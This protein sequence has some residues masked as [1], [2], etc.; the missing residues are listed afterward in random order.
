MK[1]GLA[2]RV[3]LLTATAM[4]AF[5]A[6]SVLNRLAFAQGEMEAFTYAGVRL[7]A[8][9]MI[10]VLILTLRKSMPARRRIGGSIRGAS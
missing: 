3:S 1:T 5:A 10:L 8:G 6:D 4:L 2:L 9:A 7:A